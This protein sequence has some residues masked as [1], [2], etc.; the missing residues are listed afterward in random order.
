LYDRST[1]ATAAA[2]PAVDHAGRASVVR[3]LVG[4]AIFAGLTVVGANIYIPLIPV[5]V[6][7]QTLFVL[8]AGAT[9]GSR[10]G[11]LSQLLY[12][13]L[14]VSGLPVFA[15]HLAGWSVIAGPTGGYLLSFLIVPILVGHL[16]RRSPTIRWHAFVFSVGTAVVFALGVTHLAV[17][18]AS[19]LPTALRL[20]LLPFIPGAVF[21]IVAAT[22]ISRSYGALRRRDRRRPI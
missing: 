15:G 10:Y 5:P 16:I 21:K 8:L 18:F 14:G 7:L 19:D 1:V 3:G 4:A 6:T 13:G 9:I 12:V 17:F 20:G 11:A 2:A 22:S